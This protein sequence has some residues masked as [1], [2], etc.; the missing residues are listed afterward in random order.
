MRKIHTHCDWQRLPGKEVVPVS[1]P[2]FRIL[3]HSAHCSVCRERQSSVSSDSETALH[4]YA[5]IRPTHS[6]LFAQGAEGGNLSFLLCVSVWVF[7]LNVKWKDTLHN[8]GLSNVSEIV[9]KFGYEACLKLDNNWENWIISNLNDPCSCVAL[10]KLQCTFHTLPDFRHY[11]NKWKKRGLPSYFN[12]L[13]T[14]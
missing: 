4:T 11:S 8:W 14:S 12:N 2:L 7:A 1:V 5:I 3:G 6:R 9:C 10:K 13:Y